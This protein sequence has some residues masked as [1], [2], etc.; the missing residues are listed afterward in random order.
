VAVISNRAE[1]WTPGGGQKPDVAAS[2]SVQGVMFPISCKNAKR[3]NRIPRRRLGE[4][5]DWASAYGPY[6]HPTR[7]FSPEDATSSPH[8]PTKDIAPFGCMARNVFVFWGKCGNPHGSSS[9]LAGFL[10]G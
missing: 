5:Y 3:P 4:E 1:Y 2:G 9:P 7:L 10:N 8:P 6:A